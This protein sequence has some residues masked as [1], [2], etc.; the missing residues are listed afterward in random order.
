M[1]NPILQAHRK[2]EARKAAERK[3][4]DA[5]RDQAL[6]KRA[7]QMRDAHQG[8][9]GPANDGHNMRQDPAW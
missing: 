5:L 6:L 1:T 9:Y 7:T 2:V 8:D 4:A 3:A